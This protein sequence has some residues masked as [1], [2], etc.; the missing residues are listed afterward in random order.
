MLSIG[1][2]LVMCGC[3][4]SE[5]TVLVKYSIYEKTDVANSSGVWLQEPYLARNAKATCTSACNNHL[6]CS[7]VTLNTS[8]FCTLYGDQVS[9]NNT[10]YSPN[11]M[12]LAKRELTGC[13]ANYYQD[14]DQRVCR[15][16]K[17][18]TQRCKASIECLTVLGLGCVNGS[19][20]CSI[21]PN[22]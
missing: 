5:A 1:W 13:V 4:L 6:S 11:T 15:Y 18:Y 16:Q 22:Q 2:L 12:I 21:N 10:L 17:T 20:D 14:F 19:C 8:N 3:C 7:F 9:L